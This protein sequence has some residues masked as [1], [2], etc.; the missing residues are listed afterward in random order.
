MS[1]P[2]A[3]AASSSA[4]SST[5][6][7]KKEAKDK[8]LIKIRPREIRLDTEA[9]S[10][11]AT[12]QFTL[13]V[14][15]LS[16]QKMAFKLRST[17]ASAYMVRPS[18]GYLASHSSQVCSIATRDI[19]TLPLED[20]FNIQYVLVD[21]ESADLAAFW[22]DIQKQHNPKSGVRM[23]F[24]KKVPCIYVL[25]AAKRAEELSKKGQQEAELIAK[26]DR[27]KKATLDLRAVSSAPTPSASSSSTNAGSSS[28]SSIGNSLF[29][30]PAIITTM[31]SSHGM[32]VNTIQSNISSLYSAPTS[33]SSSSSASLSSLSSSTTSNTQLPLSQSFPTSSSS[34]ASST[35]PIRQKPNVLLN[36]P[37]YLYSAYQEAKKKADSYDEAIEHLAKLTYEHEGA[38][39]A[40]QELEEKFAMLT[41]QF[42]AQK[43][44]NQ[45]DDTLQQRRKETQPTS[46]AQPQIE[47]WNAR[48]TAGGV[49]LSWIQLLLL[50]IVLVILTKNIF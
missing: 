12:V 47:K 31:P 11:S 8:K 36:D 42:E 16:N 5:S 21:T 38:K 19:P 6:L 32:N 4:S 33:M 30:T 28:S 7:E 15:N 41:K 1:Q 20:R 26:E 45:P 43:S 17:R 29:S 34:S 23:Y 3:S 13:T 44:A 39:R 18:M 14:E 48:D 24:E 25:P 50:C 35:L 22:K 2:P 9:Q 49:R 46:G 37:E 10:D 40:Y 27:E